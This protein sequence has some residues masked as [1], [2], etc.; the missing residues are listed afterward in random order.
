MPLLIKSR[1]NN[2]AFV[3]DLRSFECFRQNFVSEE[4]NAFCDFGICLSGAWRMAFTSSV[5]QIK[6]ASASHAAHMTQSRHFFSWWQLHST[7]RSGLEHVFNIHLFR[8]KLLVLIKSER[9]F[10]LLKVCV[11]SDILCR[12]A[13]CWWFSDASNLYNK[14]MMFLSLDLIRYGSYMCEK[15]RQLLHCKYGEK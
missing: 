9:R 10:M 11:L 6:A 7:A 2:I 5:H 8:V 14:L 3:F 4:F 12:I 1:F 15:I 13:I